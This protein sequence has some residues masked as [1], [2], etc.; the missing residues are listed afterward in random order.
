MYLAYLD[1]SGDAGVHNS[2]T[3]FFVLSCVLVHE[4][5]WLQTLDAVVSLRRDLRVVHNIPT[6]PELKGRHFRKGRGP[7]ARLGWSLNDRMQLLRELLQAIGAN[8]PVR[9]FAVAINKQP[10]DALGWN[11]WTA[12]WTFALQRINRFC[13]NREWAMIFPDEGHGHL[14]RRN[15]RRMRRHHMVSS[16][17]GPGTTPIPLQRIVEDPNDRGS[18]DSYFIQLADW[19][20]YVA[21]RSGHVQ[22]TRR[23]PPDLWDE[24]GATLLLEVNALRGGPPGIVLYP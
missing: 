10:A 15:L 6:R 23:V 14:I 8:V 20:A 21:H 1:E 16:F 18:H 3:Q 22:Q 7:L 9:V 19:C 4:S 12:A 2:P 11:P 17:W 5:S 24:L 13:E